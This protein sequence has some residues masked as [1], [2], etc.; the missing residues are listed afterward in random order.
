[1]GARAQIKDQRGHLGIR[2]LCSASAGTLLLDACTREG[3]ERSAS[4]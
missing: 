4:V 3:A 1:M 2:T